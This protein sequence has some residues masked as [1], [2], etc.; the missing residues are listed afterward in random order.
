MARLF[1]KECN[2]V[3]LSFALLPDI[4]DLLM[5]ILILSSYELCAFKADGWLKTKSC[6]FA[7][8]MYRRERTEAQESY[9]VCLLRRRVR[10]ARW[11]YYLT[12]IPGVLLSAHW[13]V[14]CT[15]KRARHRSQS[16]MAAIDSFQ[17]VQHLGDRSLCDQNVG[18]DI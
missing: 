3:V 9:K 13:A 14:L 18:Q 8:R 17:Q 7:L 15:K 12:F 2:G 4:N 5:T 1:A 6:T 10:G 11:V 16:V